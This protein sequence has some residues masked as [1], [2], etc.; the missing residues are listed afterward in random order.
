MFKREYIWS[1]LIGIEVFLS[2]WI[3]NT[4]INVW[5]YAKEPVQ[6]ELLTTLATASSLT[7]QSMTRLNKRASTWF[8]ARIYNIMCLHGHS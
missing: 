3:N 5:K 8:S 4:D 6:V 7:R 2:Y 1:K